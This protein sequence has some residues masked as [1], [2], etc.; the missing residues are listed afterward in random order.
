[1]F[2]V[3]I[4]TAQSEN[5]CWLLTLLSYLVE[6]YNVFQKNHTSRKISEKWVHDRDVAK[7]PIQDAV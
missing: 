6:S 2:S 5:K 1:M 3:A 4:K 7:M